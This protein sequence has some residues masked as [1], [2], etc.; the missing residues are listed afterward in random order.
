MVLNLLKT[1]ISIDSSTIP[2]ANEAVEF[3]GNW[4]KSHGM[5]VNFLEN[6]GRKML[7]T[8][9]GSGEFTLVL[10][11]HV[12]IVAG[13]HGQFFPYESNGKLYGRGSADMKAGV[14][15]MMAAIVELKQ[16]KL[17][18]KVQLQIVSDEETGGENCSGFLSESGYRGDFVIC[19]EPTGL[20]IAIQA[21]G[22]L[23]T[24]ITVPGKSAHG[25]RP[26]EGINA[27]EQA[28]EIFKQIKDLRFAKESSEYYMHPSINLAKVAAGDAYN[29]VPDECTIGL[30]IRYLPGQNPE[31]IL[32][33]IKGISPE[34]SVVSG[35]Q[36]DPINT[37][38]KHP[39]LNHLDRVIKRHPGRETVYFGQH[40]SADTVYFAK[41]GIPAIEFGPSGANWHGDEEY[42]EIESV[43][44]FRNILVE[45][46]TEL[47]F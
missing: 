14:A 16:Y 36:A 27:I 4:L 41:H 6:N 24:D 15:A 47:I 44:A 11:G 31:E 1:L 39:F 22:I 23:R 7:V 46:A 42:V 40:G 29:V 5:E 12:D 3:C 38:P 34:I 9:V 28:Y 35:W 17:G 25:S 26:W 10:N 32:E 21:K 45:L 20:R 37:D 8:E 43:F 13:K 33:Q 18:I 19:G 2:G 30:D